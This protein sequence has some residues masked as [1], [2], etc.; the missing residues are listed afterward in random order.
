MDLGDLANRRDN[1]QAREEAAAHAQQTQAGLDQIQRSLNEQHSTQK[2]EKI[3]GDVLFQLSLELDE[4]LRV[5]TDEPTEEAAMRIANRYLR[6]PIDAFIDHNNH[7]ALEY[8]E[9]ANKSKATYS[10]LMG[11]EWFK[12][13]AEEVA[14]LMARESAHE[15]KIQAQKDAKDKALAPFIERANKRREAGCGTVGFLSV[16]F[17]IFFLDPEIAFCPACIGGGLFIVWAYRYY[18]YEPPPPSVN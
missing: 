11:N 17:F 12:W 8:K 16:A 13:G 3:H 15:R 5:I 10:Q 6:D 7:P 4:D 14:H 2:R 9:L 18:N 1:Q